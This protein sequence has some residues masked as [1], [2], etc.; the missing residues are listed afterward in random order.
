[1][2]PKAKF[3]QEEILAA[4]LEL[5]RAR[6][7]DALT[8][9]ALGAALGSSARPVF[10]AFQNMEEIRQGV[11]RAAKDLYAG[12]IRAGLSQRQ[13]PAFKGVG[14]GYINFAL[15]EPRLFQ[16]LFMSRQQAGTTMANVLPVIDENYPQI[17]RSIETGYGMQRQTAQR[18][19]RHLWV[20][21][22]GI[23]VLCATNMCAFTAEEISRMLTEVCTAIIK[24]LKAG[25]QG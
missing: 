15:Q 20:Y 16:L 21:T 18:L 7:G 17:L 2:P 10:T 9:R 19:Y 1:M 13:M 6:G 11:T 5:V 4:A 22:H 8:A 14:V 3:T 25:E 23:A 12:Y 24:E